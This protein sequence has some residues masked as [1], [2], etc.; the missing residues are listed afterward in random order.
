MSYQEM[1]DSLSLEEK[2]ALLQ[3]A[4]TFGGRPNPRL[5]IPAVAFSDGPNGLRHQA[6]AADHLGLNGSEPATCFP[7]AVTVSNS[8]DPDLGERIGHAMRIG[9][10]MQFFGARANLAKCLLYAINGG[11]D[12]LEEVQIG[13]KFRPV[14]GDVLD[15][16]DVV[17]KF[18]A[19]MGWLS[20]VYVSSLNAIHYMP[21]A[22]LACT[23][24]TIGTSA[25]LR[26]RRSYA[27]HYHSGRK[28]RQ[29]RRVNHR[30]SQ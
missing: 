27:L 11:V 26:P 21:K 19:M 25:R 4:T 23:R 17:D 1:L 12:E 18:N 16:D 13:P 7:T 30:G 9:K 22:R 14:E 24:C 8:W 10:E 28:K 15:Y 6:G 20:A 2:C 5:G 29:L 3:G